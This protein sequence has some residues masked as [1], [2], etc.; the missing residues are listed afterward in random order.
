M[1]FKQLW[2]AFDQF[3]NAL[4]AGWADET[5]SCRSWRQQHKPR[6]AIAVKVING[7]FFWQ[8]NHCRGAYHQE[9]QRMHI[10]PELRTTG[11]V[12]SEEAQ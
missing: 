4:L 5:L 9:R 2:I 6:Y 3:V 8:N 7:I 12:F 1:Y 11:T 10:A